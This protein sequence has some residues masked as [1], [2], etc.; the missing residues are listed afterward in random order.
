MTYQP[1]LRMHESH[2]KPRAILY[3]KCNNDD[4]DVGSIQIR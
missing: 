4:D 1:P 2:V 3:S